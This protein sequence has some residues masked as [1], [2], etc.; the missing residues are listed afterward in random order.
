MEEE[1]LEFAC[2]QE[3]Y[4]IWKTSCNEHL[5]SLHYQRAGR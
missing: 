4:H 1:P 3:E 2:G 5:Q